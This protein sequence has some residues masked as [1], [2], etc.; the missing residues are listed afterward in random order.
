MEEIKM[1][2][3]L[4]E[5]L[6]SINTKKTEVK[7]LVEAGKLDEA[8]EAKDSLKEMQAEFDI[9]KDLEDDEPVTNQTKP[10]QVVSTEKSF[11][12]NVRELPLNIMKEGTD[13]SGGYIVPV[14]VQTKINHYKESHKSVRDVVDVE[15]VTTNKGSRTYEKK[16][17]LTGFQKV[18]EDGK[19]Q[20]MTEPSYERVT[21]EIQDFGGYLPVSND[22]LSDTDA[23]LESEIVNW[24]GRNSLATD[25][26]EVFKL[27]KSA[28][29]EVA[30]KAGLAGIKTVANSISNAYVKCIV[31]NDDGV[32]YLDTLEDKNGRP[33]LNPDPTAPANLQLRCGAQVLPVI[34]FSNSDL[35]TDT[36][37]AVGNLIIPFIV[38]DLKEGIKL[39]DRQQ[40]SLFASNTASVTG[41]N[42]FEQR[43][44]IY[45]ADMRADYK[46]KDADAFVYAT[47]KVAK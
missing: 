36:T 12:Q 5:L 38:G 4:L 35:E 2:K 17:K 29:D 22:L 25:N 32:N 46:V 13:A 10:V 41:F 37:T 8:K 19:L 6:N 43:S 11:A 45:R 26:R 42:A 15:N 44:T 9:L 39:F 23:N 20:A 30:M 14:D 31:T 33:L 34:V 40:T 7:A 28:K 21:Y 24:V 27:A 16:A 1:N 18:T 3:K 47:M